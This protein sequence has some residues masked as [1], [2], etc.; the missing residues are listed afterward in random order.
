MNL[1]ELCTLDPV[2]CAR[3][4]TAAVA[5]QLMRDHHVGDLIVVD[6]I[7]EERYVVGVVTDRDLVVQVMSCGLAPALVKISDLIRAP[8]IIARESE[9]LS[10]ALERMR[11][12]GVRRL[13]IVDEH[14]RLAGVI[15]LDDL[16]R[17]FAD[18][19]AGMASIVARGRRKSELKER[20]VRDA[21]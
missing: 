5:A 18:E 13:P 3:S 16:L 9:D 11:S 7:T 15:T 1:S 21:C 20:V 17:I 10:T 12:H 14:E 6:D 8:V 4:A 2:C 19:V